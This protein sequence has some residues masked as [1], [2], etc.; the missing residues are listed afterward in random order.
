MVLQPSGELHYAAER[1]EA[2]DAA[3]GGGVRHPCCA[4]YLGASDKILWL[5]SSSSSSNTTKKTLNSVEISNPD[6]AY[7]LHVVGNCPA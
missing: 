7:A 5:L 6:V 3:E 2:V 4:T 1:E